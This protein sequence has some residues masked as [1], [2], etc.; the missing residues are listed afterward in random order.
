[1]GLYDVR[2]RRRDPERAAVEP[3]RWQTRAEAAAYARLSIR[4][5]DRARARGE[6]PAS[7]IGGTGRYRYL[8]ADLDAWI[9]RGRLQLAVSR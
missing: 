1:M 3:P 9:G 4:S 5:I 7:R 8:R 2:M 6:L